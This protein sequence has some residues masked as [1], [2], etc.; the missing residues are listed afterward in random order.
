MRRWNRTLGIWTLRGFLIVVLLV[1]A[2]LTALAFPYPL[3]NNVQRFDEFTVC[4]SQPLPDGY[5]QI[6]DGVRSRIEAMEYARPGAGCRVFICGDQRLY[7]LFAFLTRQSPNTMG[8]GLSLFGNV[9]LNEPMIRRV[10]R[11]NYG[12]IRH[13]RFEG[14][15]AELISHEIAHFNAVKRLGFRPSMEVPFWKSEGYAEYQA[16]LAATRADAS[17]AL[18]DRIDLLMNDSFWGR[19]A[20][21]ARRLFESH[22]LVEFLAEVKGFGLD[23]LIDESVTEELAREEMLAWY[24]EQRS[25]G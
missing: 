9:Y 19:G 4:S 22:L 15:L 23:E 2:Y 25:R 16:N 21:L 12:G 13:S 17:Y 14:N 10:A 7:S 3:F 6:I 8:I 18:T 20:S 5:G 1:A 24:E 11:Q